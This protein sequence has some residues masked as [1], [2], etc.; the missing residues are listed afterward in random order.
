[1]IYLIL[2]KGNLGSLEEL[3]GSLTKLVSG[4]LSLK[5]HWDNHLGRCKNW[6][7]NQDWSGC[8]GIINK[9]PCQEQ[10]KLISCPWHEGK[11]EYGQPWTLRPQKVKPN[12]PLSRCGYSDFPDNMKMGSHFTVKAPDRHGWSLL[13]S[14]V[15]GHVDSLIL[16]WYGVMRMAPHLPKTHYPGLIMR[17]LSGKFQHGDFP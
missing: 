4:V 6:C 5:Y 17:E 16:T 12:S 8:A 2:R 11:V 15:I 1:M 10:Q 9:S 14:T 7:I 3:L 13:T